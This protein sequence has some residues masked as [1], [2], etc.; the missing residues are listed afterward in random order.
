MSFSRLE[1]FLLVSARHFTTEQ[2]RNYLGLIFGHK[3][4]VLIKHVPK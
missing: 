4:N 2:L 3:Q 1:L